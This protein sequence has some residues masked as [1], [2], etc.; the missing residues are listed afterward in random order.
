MRLVGQTVKRITYEI[1]GVKAREETFYLS[2]VNN[3]VG[4]F[5]DFVHVLI[6]L[7]PLLYLKA[8]PCCYL[9]FTGYQKA[10]F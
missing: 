9:C 7:L 2:D 6:L 1:L 4:I 3:S 10:G 8:L 5:N